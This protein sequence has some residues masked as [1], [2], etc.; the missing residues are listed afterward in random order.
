MDAG[1]TVIY[2]NCVRQKAEEAEFRMTGIINRITEK[3]ALYIY[4]LTESL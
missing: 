4:Y 3:V 2:G 1:E